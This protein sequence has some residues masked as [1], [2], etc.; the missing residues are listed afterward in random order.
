MRVLAIETSTLAGGAAL[1]ES[2]R[3]VGEYA[4]DVRVT[5]SERVMSAVDQLIR[6][7]GWKPQDLRGVAVAVGPGSFTGL[8]IG[9]GTVKGLALSLGIPVAAVPT[10]DAMAAA[11]PFA[12]HPVCPVIDARKGEVYASLYVWTGTGMRREWDLL[13]LA[14]DVLAARLQEPTILVG[15]GA[16]GIRSPHARL[17]P[18]MPRVPSAAMVGLLG[19]EKLRRGE[20]VAPA[21]LVP[22]YL[23]PSEAELK[24]RALAL[25]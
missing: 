15:D 22:I 16:V 17:V 19:A 12:V 18:I 6:D 20:T 8:R 11:V 14:P 5:H 23:R 13:A 21:D 9:L 2:A 25:A 10:L 3:V 7:A 4:L 1:L 24:R